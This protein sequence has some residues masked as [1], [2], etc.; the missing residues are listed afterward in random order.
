MNEKGF[1]LQELL[2]FIGVS[3][4]ILVVVMIY[5]NKELKFNNNKIETSISTIA[6]PIVTPTT[7]NSNNQYMK[8]ENKIKKAAMSYNVDKDE[9]IIISLN[10]LKEKNLINYIVDPN[11]SQINCN[12]YVVYDNNAY[13][14]YINCEGMYTTKNYNKMF[15]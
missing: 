2:V 15:E 8:L 3:M 9:T 6:D 4:F 10:K 12:G 7:E 1:G 5:C 13:I 14:P 11:N